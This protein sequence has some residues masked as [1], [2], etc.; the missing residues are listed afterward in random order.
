MVGWEI[1]RNERSDN[2]ARCCRCGMSQGLLGHHSLAVPRPRFVPRP[3][4][5]SPVAAP[6]H[7]AP[8]HSPTRAGQPTPYARRAGP[9]AC[10]CAHPLRPRAARRARAVGRRHGARCECEERNSERQHV[11]LPGVREHG[12]V[13]GV[14]AAFLGSVRCYDQLMC[15][16]T[17]RS[18]I[19]CVATGRLGQILRTRPRA[20]SLS[21]R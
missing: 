19:A 2:G 12:F 11:A 10:V 4:G 14:V 16:I 15:Y 6:R 3:R 13:C 7:S 21:A 20:Q 1:E 8:P 5:H 18:Y 17:S 9:S